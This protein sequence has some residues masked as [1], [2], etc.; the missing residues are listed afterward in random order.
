MSACETA[1]PVALQLAVLS[2]GQSTHRHTDRLCTGASVA[3]ASAWEDT[4]KALSS[5]GV[6]SGLYRPVGSVSSL[7]E[8]Q[9]RPV[10]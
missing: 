3:K 6:Q 9:S 10:F 1:K 5:T 2:L 8:S 7:A 4:S